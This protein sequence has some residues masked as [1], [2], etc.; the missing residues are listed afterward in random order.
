MVCYGEESMLKTWMMVPIALLT[1]LT[2]VLAACGDDD[3]D[4]GDNDDGTRTAT[5]TRESDDETEDGDDGNADDGEEDPNATGGAGETDGANG[6]EDDT[7][8]GDE[9]GSG[10][11]DGANGS[12]SDGGGRNSSGGDEDE[13][14]DPTPSPTP[15]A[16]VCLVTAQEVSEAI[17]ESVELRSSDDGCTFHTDTFETVDVSASSLGENPE[18]AFNTGR[19]LLGGEPVDGIGD[20]AFWLP[21]FDQLN[22]RQGDQHLIVTLVL[23]DNP[24]VR[25]A[26]IEI[27]EAALTRL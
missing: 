26:G 18:E 17:G 8:D 14:E 13:D 19:D 25:E 3:D 22:V 4:S 21:G 2:L 16:R 1:V 23:E 27:A 12:G 10:D 24:N 9:N 15:N 11:G 7:G 20:D 6:D 5:S